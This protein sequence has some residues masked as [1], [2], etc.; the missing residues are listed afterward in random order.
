MYK[1]TRVELSK[2]KQDMEMF[3]HS[4]F[5]L[6]LFAIYCKWAIREKIK[7][8]VV[9]NEKKVSSHDSRKVTCIACMYYL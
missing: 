8:V 3:G 2:K 7:Y 9:L 4:C 6:A 1:K 5:I